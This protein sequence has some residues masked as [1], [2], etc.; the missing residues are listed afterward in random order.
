MPFKSEFP[1]FKRYSSSQF[2]YSEIPPGFISAFKGLILR[3]VKTPKKL[4]DVCN[5]I[6]TL[7]PCEP[8]QNW[9]W[10]WLVND[11]DTLINQLYQKRFHKFMDFIFDFSAKYFFEEDYLEDLNDL[12][13]EYDIGYRLKSD[14]VNLYWELIKEPEVEDIPIQIAKQEIK[15]I[16]I[17]AKEHL[18]Q[19]REQLLKTDN[20]RAWKDALRDCLSAMEAL[21][22]QLGNNDKIDQSTKV[23]RADG[24]WGPAIIV[25]DGLSIWNR[26]HDLY[27]DI[28]HGNPNISKISRDEALYWID[29][30]MAY[31]SYLARRKK[32]IF[33]N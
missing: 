15:D 5:D 10:D 31:I 2:Y 11:L 33:G 18:D 12:F 19:A 1:D 7:V 6:A 30:L 16:C 3:V 17:Q 23:L 9:G 22:N 25:K 27:P 29:R 20:P 32:N 26:M 21:A 14:T 13:D 8:T 28:R 24:R 4:K